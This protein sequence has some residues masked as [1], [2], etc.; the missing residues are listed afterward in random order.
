MQTLNLLVEKSTGAIVAASPV[1]KFQVPPGSDLEL[2]TGFSVPDDFTTRTH[3][4]NGGV[5]VLNP[6][7]SEAATIE[8]VSPRAI[9]NRLKALEVEVG[10]LKGPK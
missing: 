10:K 6:N 2:K 9:L 5:V 4:F 3:I 8:D 7:P 1:T